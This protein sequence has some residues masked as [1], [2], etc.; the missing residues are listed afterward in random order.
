MLE[1]YLTN[2]DIFDEELEKK[3]V[4]AI[5]QYIEV[6]DKDRSYRLQISFNVELIN[7]DRL[8][9]IYSLH[10]N[11]KIVRKEENKIHEILSWQLSKICTALED[12]GINSYSNIIEGVELKEKD[13]IKIVLKEEER[14]KETVRR[15][16]EK[17]M[18]VN[19]IMPNRQ[20]AESRMS[21][22]INAYMNERFNKVY[23]ALRNNNKLMSYFLE[24]ECTDDINFM[25]C[26]FCNTYG[27][28]LFLTTDEEKRTNQL[29][30][31]KARSSIER[32][33]SEEER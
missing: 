9:E 22:S 12:Q 25:F 19:T 24:I 15:K 26:T 29:M 10:C 17:R 33:F 30:C 5:L 21:H 6:I 2:T 16:N 3:V 1:V 13:S 27:N 23:D 31:E 18:R 28:L 32:Y 4:D 14:E 8:N 20:S 7:D 11:K